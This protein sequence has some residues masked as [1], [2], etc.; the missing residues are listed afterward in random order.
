[1]EIVVSKQWLL[2]R[3]FESDLSI[4]DCR[5]HL[6]NPEQGIK[7]YNDCRI[8]GAIYLHLNNDLSEKVES[9]GGRHPLPNLEIFTAKLASLGINPQ[10]RVVIYDN[11]AGAMAS[12]VWFLMKL[13]GHEQVFIL[14]ES[15]NNWMQN[16]YPIEE[17]T[18]S[19]RIPTSYSI[20]ESKVQ[21]ASMQEVKDS[22]TQTDVCIIDSREEIRYKG[23]EET[24]DRIAGHIP[25]AINHFWREGQ[26][27]SGSW[28]TAEEQSERF[29]GLSTEE[30]VIV[31]CGSGVTACP[32][33][34]ALLMSGFSNVKLYPGSWSDW[35]SYEENP[36]ATNHSK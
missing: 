33:V 32:N 3:L 17:T 18:P 34:V 1:M 28:K 20:G 22:L 15:F 30:N 21:I 26:D 6:N 7:E 27:E 36:I 23:I 25:G 14:R 10:T 5:F 8:P 2:A 12:R 16:N 11:Q 29:K 31:Y 24:I 19:I 13:V 35:I 4:I 9:H